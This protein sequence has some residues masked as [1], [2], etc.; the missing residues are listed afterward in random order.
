MPC[1]CKKGSGIRFTGA[2][3]RKRKR[4]GMAISGA[5]YKKRKRRRRKRKGGGVAAALF[6]PAAVAARLFVGARRLRGL[7]AGAK[8]GSGRI[9]SGATWHGY[10][11]G[12]N[13]HGAGVRGKRVLARK[14]RGKRLI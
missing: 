13:I 3:V 4:G 8:R 2:G 10:G 1:G 7:R 6:N 11:S 14:G 5:G 9:L 12:M